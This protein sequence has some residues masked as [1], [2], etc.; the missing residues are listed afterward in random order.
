MNSVRK[1]QLP[2]PITEVCEQE[3]GSLCAVRTVRVVSTD[4]FITGKEREF[5]Q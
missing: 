1:N 3:E 4:A 5:S 2:F